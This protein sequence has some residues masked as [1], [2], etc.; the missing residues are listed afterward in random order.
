[1]ETEKLLGSLHGQSHKLKWQHRR[2]RTTGIMELAV[3]RNDST[4]IQ[5]IILQTVTMFKFLGN[6][7]IIYIQK[8]TTPF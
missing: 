7:V 4:Y 3:R 6:Q 2:W 8:Q 5:N 1:M